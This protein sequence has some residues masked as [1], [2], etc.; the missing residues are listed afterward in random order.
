MRDRK[1]REGKITGEG[2]GSKNAKP[3]RGTTTLP[4]WGPPRLITEAGG[5]FPLHRCK[6]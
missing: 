1:E 6:I 4:E 3:R 5:A 2:E